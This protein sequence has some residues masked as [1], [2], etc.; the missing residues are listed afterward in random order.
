MQTLWPGATLPSGN[1]VWEEAMIPFS[2]W[3]VLPDIA[4]IP[5][6]VRLP[7]GTQGISVWAPQDMVWYGLD[8]P[9]D[10]IEAPTTASPVLATDFAFG[11]CAMPGQWQSFALPSP[12]LAHSLYLRSTVENA[13]LFV[14]AQTDG[15]S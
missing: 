6:E 4:N 15:S 9:P 10:P 14:T 12:S 5:K 8:A 7:A 13:L 11:T 3:I 1:L 2:R